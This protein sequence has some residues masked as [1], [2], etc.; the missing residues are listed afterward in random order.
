MKNQVFKMSEDATE[1]QLH[2]DNL[3]IG[4]RTLVDGIAVAFAVKCQQLR[5]AG[6]HT[7]KLGSIALNLIAH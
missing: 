6:I 2:F 7:H 3:T 5:N 1:V 4:Y